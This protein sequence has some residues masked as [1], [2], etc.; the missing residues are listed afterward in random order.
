MLLCIF[1]ESL[2]CRII[3]EVTVIFS[4]YF[5]VERRRERGLCWQLFSLSLTFCLKSQLVN[6]CRQDNIISHG[7]FL[8]ICKKDHYVYLDSLNEIQKP[9]CPIQLLF[10]TAIARYINSQ[11]EFLIEV[12]K[13]TRL[14]D[15]LPRG[16]EKIKPAPR[17]IF[18]DFD[19]FP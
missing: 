7:L 4:C 8:N 15:D 6:F 2:S 1:L 18:I 5:Q 11:E 3:E 9:E 12:V 14:A 16:Q 10:R 17:E 19:V 13:I